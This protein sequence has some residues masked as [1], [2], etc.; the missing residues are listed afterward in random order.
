MVWIKFFFRRIDPSPMEMIYVYLLNFWQG[1][2]LLNYS[3]IILAVPSVLLFN[4]FDES[5]F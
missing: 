1:S 3:N 2:E 4:P 5:S